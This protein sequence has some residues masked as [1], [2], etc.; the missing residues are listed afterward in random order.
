MIVRHLVALVLPG[1][2]GGIGRQPTVF[3]LQS[4]IGIKIKLKKVQLG[5]WIIF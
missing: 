5:N 2:V 3:F 4:E 1:D